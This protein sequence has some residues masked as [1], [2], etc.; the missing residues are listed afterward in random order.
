ITRLREAASLPGVV[1]GAVIADLRQSVPVQ[2]GHGEPF[3]TACLFP[4]LV[5]PP[6]WS[7]AGRAGGVTGAAGRRVARLG[8]SGRQWI[9]IAC[10]LWCGR[11]AR[12]GSGERTGPG[13][14]CTLGGETGK[15][16]SR[17]AGDRRET[18][19]RPRSFGKEHPLSG[20]GGL[21]SDTS[22]AEV[23]VC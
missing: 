17:V 4:P 21:L 3:A 14:G 22:F 7:G 23:P 19:C 12:L 9:G 6:R 10:F 15:G 18:G 8:A 16:P 5:A 11:K 20:G 13:H 1:P 2:P